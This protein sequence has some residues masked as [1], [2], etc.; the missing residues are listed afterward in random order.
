MEEKLEIANQLDSYCNSQARAKE[1]LV[2][3]VM[4]RRGER[5]RCKRHVGNKIPIAR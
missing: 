5:L 4:M 3:A 2:R 1:G